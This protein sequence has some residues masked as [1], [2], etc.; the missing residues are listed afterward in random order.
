MSDSAPDW[1]GFI[2][3][4]G[5]A[6][7]LFARQVAGTRADAE[8]AV[9][10]GFLRFWKTGSTAEEPARFFACIR[11]AALDLLRSGGRRHRR[12][13][14]HLIESSLLIGAAEEK[15]TREQIERAL[16]HLP[17]PQ[18][19][20]V[21]LKIWSSLTFLQIA[22]ILA[23]SPNTVATRYRYAMQKLEQLLSPEF[24]HER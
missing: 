6:A 18:R 1:P 13:Q 21:V 12:E 5:P 2:A 19:E 3:R 4:H 16:A 8:D 11:H 23:E 10:D 17:P 15:E 22:Q 24:K 7:L 14:H 9:H 20:V